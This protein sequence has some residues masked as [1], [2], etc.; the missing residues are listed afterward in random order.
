MS[1]ILDISC[2]DSV[3]NFSDHLPIVFKLRFQFPLA[4]LTAHHDAS[5]HSDLHSAD[6]VDWNKVTMQQA[7]NFCDFLHDQL[8][9]IPDDLVD[10]CDPSCTFHHQ[11]L[12]SLCSQLLECMQRGSSTCLTKAK[13]CQHLISGW[14]SLARS[15]KHS[16]AFWH[17]LWCDSGCSSSG[18]LFQIKKLAKKQFK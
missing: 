1:Q 16:A 5:S 10:C 2:F 13:T 18:V 14:N 8:P 11:E 9:V 7:Q 12:D 6:I 15:L 3:E 17:R 4:V